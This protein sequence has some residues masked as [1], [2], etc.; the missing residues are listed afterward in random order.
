MVRGIKTGKMEEIPVAMIVTTR[1]LAKEANVDARQHNVENLSPEVGK[2]GDPP[3]EDPAQGVCHPDHR[4]EE[5]GVGK[6]EPKTLSH[7]QV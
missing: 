1:A 2:I 5:G 6:R 7:L 4:D 3:R